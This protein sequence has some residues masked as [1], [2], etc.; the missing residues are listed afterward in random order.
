MEFLQVLLLHAA[1]EAAW[2]EAGAEDED[3]DLL[4]GLII[5]APVTKMKESTQGGT[6]LPPAMEEGADL[7]NGHK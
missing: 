6:D 2:T 4:L 3:W 5:G 7:L 1:E